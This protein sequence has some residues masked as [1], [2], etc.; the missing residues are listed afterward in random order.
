L[1]VHSSESLR[2]MLPFGSNV[3][4]RWSKHTG[5]FPSM[6]DNFHANCAFFTMAPC[7]PYSST[8]THSTITLYSRCGSFTLWLRHASVLLTFI[9]RYVYIMSISWLYLSGIPHS[10][11]YPLSVA[12]H[13]LSKGAARRHSQL[14]LTA[15]ILW[16]LIKRVNFRGL[17]IW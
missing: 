15:I 16:I 8:R 17:Q 14:P 5:K 7:F 13:A 10:S 4:M 12:Q 9:L 1:R 11:F 2:G 3:W 6:Q